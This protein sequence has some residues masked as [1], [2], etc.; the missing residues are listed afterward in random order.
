[1]TGY[2]WKYLRYNIRGHVNAR[3]NIHNLIF[4]VM[5]IFAI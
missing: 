2:Q 1:M 3:G 4:V 5:L